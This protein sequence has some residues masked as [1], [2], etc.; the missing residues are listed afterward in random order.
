M[1]TTPDVNGICD[2]EL[3][4]DTLPPATREAFFAIRTVDFLEGDGWYLAGG[5]ALALQVG[6][7][8]SVTDWRCP[9][10]NASAVPP[11]RYHPSPSKKST[12]RM[13][14]NASRVAGG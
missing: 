4:L 1:V 8:Q 5:T 2:G 7:R 12:V 13:A 11:A 3:H 6:H 14:K 9:T 10:C